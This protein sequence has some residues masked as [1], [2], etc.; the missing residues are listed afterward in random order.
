MAVARLL[1]FRLNDPHP[2]LRH[3]ALLA[4]EGHLLLLLLLLRR[5]GVDDGEAHLRSLL[6]LSNEICVACLQKG[7]SFGL[8]RLLC[9]SALV[10]DRLPPLL[11][12]A[13]NPCLSLTIDLF[14]RL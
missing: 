9:N 13:R 2:L 6:L 4:H 14:D 10:G 5:A 12:L 1:P 7:Q 11:Q 8:D 3:D